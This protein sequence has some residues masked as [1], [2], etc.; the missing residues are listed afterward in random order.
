MQTFAEKLP[1][2]ETVYRAI[3]DRILYGDLAP[4]QMVTIQG[5][6]AELGVSMTPVREAIRRLTAAGAL[7]FQGNRRVSVPIM[8]ERRFAELAFARLSIEPQLAEMA[9]KNM[10]HGN[11]DAMK[12]EDLA[13]DQ[14]ISAG[15]AQGYMRQ[16]Y[17]F[18][19][20]LYS[21]ANS[22][23]LMPIAETL[24]LRFGPVSRIICG[25]YGTANIDDKHEEAMKALAE[26]NH[27]GVARAIHSDIAQGLEIVRSE[28]GWAPI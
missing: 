1:A 5:L 17:R 23:V 16:N 22:R 12:I 25:K 28:F 4:G 14:A 6:V 27:H 21:G 19:F 15:D 18:H 13:L 2:H 11:L 7:E 26:R 9:S 8:G 24:W 10:L 3:R 20:A